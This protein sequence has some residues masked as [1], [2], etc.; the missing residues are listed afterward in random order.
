MAGVLTRVPNPF[1]WRSYV[2]GCGFFTQKVA[3]TQH[4]ANSIGAHNM[5]RVFNVLRCSVLYILWLH[6]NDCMMNGAEPNQMYIISRAQSHVTLHLDRLRAAGNPR[7]QGLCRRWRRD[8]GR[9]GAYR[10]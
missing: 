9:R 5:L 8:H 3:F 2:G 4:V 10:V 6:H 1:D 7:L